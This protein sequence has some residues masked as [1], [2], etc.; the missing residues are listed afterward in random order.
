MDCLFC[1]IV[2]GETTGA[3]VLSDDDFV[4]FL[5]EGLASPDGDATWPPAR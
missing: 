1:S 4:G 5:E 2:A 3:L